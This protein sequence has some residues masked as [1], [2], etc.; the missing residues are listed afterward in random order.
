M[1]LEII[2]YLFP[3]RNNL[4]EEVTYPDAS[5]DLGAKSGNEN[6]KDGVRVR[7]DGGLDVDAEEGYSKMRF[8]VA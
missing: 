5:Q 8:Q 6:A 7:K 4:F 3:F 2:R 1:T